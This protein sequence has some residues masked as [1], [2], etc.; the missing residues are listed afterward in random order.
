MGGNKFKGS[1][2][3]LHKVGS[4]PTFRKK[5]LCDTLLNYV[6]K[7]VHSD[8][9]KVILNIGKLKIKFLR[10]DKGQ[11]NGHIYLRTTEVLTA[12]WT[13][14][15]RRSWNILKIKRSHP[16]ACWGELLIES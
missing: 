10:E 12:E 9:W 1:T 2:N 14:N 8:T 11:I 7:L 6:G 5:F 15:L 13:C 16:P 4:K 3:P